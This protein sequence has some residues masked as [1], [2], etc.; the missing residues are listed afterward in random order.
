MFDFPSSIAEAS[1]GKEA[2]DYLAG[3]HVDVV[4][5]DIQMPVMNGIDAMREIRNLPSPPKVIVLT[6]FEEETLII[7]IRG[8]RLCLQELR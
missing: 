1:N 5:L 3:N 6:Q 8:K 7:Q 4:L 2:L